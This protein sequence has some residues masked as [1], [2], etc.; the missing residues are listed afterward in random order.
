M[1]SVIYTF[2]DANKINGSLFYCYEYFLILDELSNSKFIITDIYKE[3]DKKLIQEAIND[4]Y[5]EEYQKD[6]IFINKKTDIYK[7]T[8]EYMKCL[9]LDI[10]TY[11]NV[12][13]LLA[14]KKENQY[15][16]IDEYYKKFNIPNLY[17]SYGSYYYQEPYGKFYYL[18][19]GFKYHKE[20]SCGE[21]TFIS[22]RDTEYI[23]KYEKD[24]ILLKSEHS[25]LKNLFN[26]IN[27][28]VYIHLKLDT[29][30]RIIPEAFYHNKEVEIINEL[31]DIKDST[32]LRYF[33]ILKNG[34]D[35]YTLTENDELIKEIING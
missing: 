18:K 16:F 34:L 13:Q 23:K 27:K 12:Y 7:E 33:D 10:N 19:L 35:N 14:P 17:N 24:N 4:K 29:N 9:I 25:I 6:I 15:V 21:K 20:C 2:I 3:E 8:K 26:K 31:K 30:N 28:I 22:S 1:C 5:K 11:M 32:E